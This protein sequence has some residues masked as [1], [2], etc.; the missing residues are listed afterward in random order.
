MRNDPVVAG[1]NALPGPYPVQ[2]AAARVVKL[3]AV[4]DVGHPD[5]RGIQAQAR[6]RSG[7]VEGRVVEIGA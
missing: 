6:G 3:H 4:L 5:H 7:A 2:L 1:E